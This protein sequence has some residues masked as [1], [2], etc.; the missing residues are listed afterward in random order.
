MIIKSKSGRDWHQAEAVIYFGKSLRLRSICNLL[1]K[2]PSEVT[3]GS[4][5]KV[6]CQSCKKVIE[7]NIKL[8]EAL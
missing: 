7:R 4:Y 2:L 8:K 3:I 5:E 6:T 1:N